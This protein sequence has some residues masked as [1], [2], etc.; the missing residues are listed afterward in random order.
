MDVGTVGATSLSSYQTALKSVAQSAAS[1]GSAASTSGTGQ[2]ATVLQALSAAYAN[3]TGSSIGTQPA[4]DA[5]SFLAGSDALSTLAKGIYSASAASGDA[6]SSI[7]SLSG[8]LAK[9][10]ELTAA[11]P[12]I[13]NS[14]QGTS[15]LD[16][17]SSAAINL[18]ATLALASYTNRQNGIPD[19]TIGAAAAKLASGID[20]TQ[21][22]SVQAAIQA[23]QAISMAS[24]LNLIG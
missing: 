5:L 22:A 10:G 1:T 2:S 16:G 14:G 23:A 18:D 12:S 4:S 15:G 17:F 19:G 3:L 24:T 9:V 13:L 6:A 21:T 7:S 20:T 8:S 11:S